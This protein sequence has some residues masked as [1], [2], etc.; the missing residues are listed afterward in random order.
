MGFLI[1]LITC[2]VAYA[3]DSIPASSLEQM[4][5]MD[6][7]AFKTDKNRLL[8]YFWATWC[9][10]CKVKLQKDLPAF[11]VPENSQIITINTDKDMER[12]KHF[13]EKE[14]LSVNVV[15]E[16]DKSLSKTLKVFSVPFWAVLERDGE[17][18][19]VVDSKS[20]G[21][22]EKMKAAMWMSR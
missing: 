10:D 7:S 3:A 12:A 16:T 15:R 13:I 17:S 14:S 21:N 22:S 8:M 6:G 5:Q 19:K 1:A 9:T 20:G 18:W 2:T 11:K 4:K